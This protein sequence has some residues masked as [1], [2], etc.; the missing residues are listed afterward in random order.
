VNTESFVASFAEENQL[1]SAVGQVKK[2]GYAIEDIYVPYP[3]HG[4]EE[5]LGWRRSRLA[6]ACFLGGVLG[7]GSILWFQFWASA[8]SWPLNVGGRPWNSLPAFIPATFECMVL[9]GGFALVFAWLVRCRL[10]PGKEADMPLAGW[11]DNR[12]ALLVQLPRSRI[13]T[14]ELRKVLEE[15]GAVEMEPSSEEEQQ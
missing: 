7:A 12:F 3:V 9:F 13:K 15:C 10:Y 1:L 14:E 6:V 11:T 8:S 4:L 5:L 2:R